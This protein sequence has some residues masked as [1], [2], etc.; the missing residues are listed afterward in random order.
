MR[1]SSLAL[2]VLFLYSF[3]SVA[4]ET[5]EY[6]TIDQGLSQNYIFS[7]CQDSKG[8]I[9]IG[10][11]DGLNRFDGKRF[12]CYRHDPFDSSSLSGNSVSIIYK[13]SK[14]RLWV[15]TNGGGLNL[16]NPSSLAFKHYIAGQNSKTLSSNFISCIFECSNGLI[17]IGTN[18]GGLNRLDPVTGIITRFKYNP[19]VSNS[20]SS[21]F[22]S[23]IGESDDNII[24][25]AT[26]NGGLNRFDP[27]SNRFTH[28]LP[29][30]RKGKEL[31]FMN[32][33]TSILVDKNGLVWFG[34]ASGLNLYNPKSDS[35]E[36]FSINDSDGYP[37]LINNILERNGKLY[38]S[39]FH[40]LAVFDKQ[41]EKYSLLT[42]T[43]T[44]WF[45]NAAC[46]DKSG[47]LW[48]GTG[49][50]GTSKFNPDANRFNSKKGTFL[51]EVFPIATSVLKK[52]FGNISKQLLEGRGTEFLP[53]RKNSKGEYLVA[54][55]RMGLIIIDSSGKSF[56]KI[57]SNPSNIPPVPVWA[58]NDVFEDK[59]NNV[60]IA[61]VGGI[62]KY[63]SLKKTFTHYRLYDEKKISAEYIN[64]SGAA[65]YSDI[66]VTFVDDDNIFWLG[67]PD[68]GLILFDNKKNFIKYFSSKD[69]RRESI[70]NDHIL[71]IAKDELNPGKYLWVGTE[72]G[73]LNHFEITTGNCTH[74]T[75]ENGLPNNVVYGI[76]HGSDGNLWLSTNRGISC[77]NPVSK[78]FKNYDVESGLQSNEFNRRE[79]YSSPD[80]KLYFG[81]IQG[82]NS[83]YPENIKINNNGPQI[84]ITDFKLFNKHISF[85]EAGSPLK[86]SIET[87][88]DILL[89]YFQNVITFEFAALEYTAPKLNTYKYML[90]GF[91]HEWVYPGRAREATFT[92]LDP[93]EYTFRVKGANS[94]GVWGTDEASIKII[95][96]PPYYMTWWFKTAVILFVLIIVGLTIRY[97]IMRKVKEKIIKSEH[98][99][100]ME[101]ERLRIARDLHDDIGSR[102]TELRMISEMVSKK[103]LHDPD[104]KQK[105]KELSSASENVISTFGEI[106]WSLN[107]KN[108]SFEELVEFL[109]QQS[110]DFLSKADIRC[111]LELPDSL[112]NYMVSSEIRHN[113]IFTIKELM[114][115]IVKH[116]EAS[117]VQIALEINEVELVFEV[118]DNGI[119]FNIN[120]TRKYGNGLNNIKSRIESIGCTISIESK[121][122]HGTLTRISIPV[123]LLKTV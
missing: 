91:N 26:A 117:I 93:G 68:R 114:N 115:N 11:K 20:I 10:T 51:T 31:R 79:Y 84:V 74:Y 121:I 89:D 7:I 98:E 25:I 86:E 43:S 4:Q 42:E 83:F 17:W 56:Q 48:L 34:S 39:S 37:C 120:N 106:V 35:L 27:K 55:P 47:I 113:L 94:D 32:D 70:N 13:D 61:T 105:L 21:N 112:P 28:I 41:T 87:T 99:A 29:N 77:F 60:W 24:W 6:L 22:I 75:T 5:I 78:E 104:V 59:E 14:H 3:I 80:G 110:T 85:K 40:T 44:E 58:V 63:D 69:G 107:P 33:A 38:L 66:T 9:W 45:T 101:R 2:T 12:I 50:W 64:K 53:I 65:G 76:L 111:R 18:D 71:S 92:N 15:G 81:G 95:I 23:G 73:G 122:D 100:A 109:S 96:L 118:K 19:G 67:T 16:F 49:G 8:F 116:A 54:T 46:F 102:L 90:E 103:D 30:D 82:Y 1:F 108:D 97:F 88:T 123:G 62:S 72:G 119:G 36:K 57:N 52:H